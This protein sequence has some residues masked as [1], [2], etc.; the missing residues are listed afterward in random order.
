MCL[1]ERARAL[2]AVPG[3]AGAGPVTFLLHLQFWFKGSLEKDKTEICSV[4]ESRLHQEEA[5]SAAAPRPRMSCKPPSPSLLPPQPSDPAGGGRRLLKRHQQQSSPGPWT[6]EWGQ[7]ETASTHWQQ[8]KSLKTLIHIA[9][10][11]L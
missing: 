5:G 4:A 2:R 8:I 3:P 10:C 6:G 9:I 1:C 11:T 7:G